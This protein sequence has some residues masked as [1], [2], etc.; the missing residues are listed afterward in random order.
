MTIRK[1]ET[2]TGLDIIAENRRGIW[3]Y[4]GM[5]GTATVAASWSE[6]P[7]VALLELI[8]KAYRIRSQQAMER[9]N[10]RCVRCGSL[11]GLQA[12][13]IISR[14]RGRSDLMSAL[15]TL[16]CRCHQQQHAWSTK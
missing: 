10:Y 5:D 15:Q 7:R 2:I 8:Q 13:H 11:D 14:S 1:A 12:H 9:D 6:S 4:T 16:C 3:Y